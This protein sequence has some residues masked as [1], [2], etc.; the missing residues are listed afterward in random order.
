MPEKKVVFTGET[1][2][3]TS[4]QAFH[5]KAHIVYP[6]EGGTALITFEEE[7]GEVTI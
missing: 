4:T 3:A 6:M 7:I 2:D 5:M 1:G